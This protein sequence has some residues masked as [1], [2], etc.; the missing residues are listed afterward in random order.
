MMAQSRA[1]CRRVD[2]AAQ[3]GAMAPEVVDLSGRPV[4]PLY[5]RQRDH[6]KRHLEALR[7]RDLPRRTRSP[8]RLERMGARAYTG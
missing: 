6:M 3:G 5:Q 2:P 1:S 7:C 8:P 4:T